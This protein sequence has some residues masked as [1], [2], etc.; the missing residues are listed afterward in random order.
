MGCRTGFYVS[1]LTPGDT[2]SLQDM[3]EIATEIIPAALEI[4]KLPGA[5]IETCGAYLE[6]DFQQARQELKTLEKQHIV[7]LENP[8]HLN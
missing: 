3:A 8:L 2:L 6:H 7:A 1:I 5:T 4:E